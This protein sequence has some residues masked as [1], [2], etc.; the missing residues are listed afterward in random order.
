MCTRNAPGAVMSRDVG[1]QSQKRLSPKRALGERESNQL[2]QKKHGPKFMDGSKDQLLSH[3]A[4]KKLV[5][6]KHSWALGRLRS[7]AFH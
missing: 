1:D 2:R 3:E 6:V 4:P 7:V 5:I